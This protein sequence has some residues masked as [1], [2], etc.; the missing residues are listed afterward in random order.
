MIAN[1]VRDGVAVVTCPNR[2]TAQK[3][4]DEWFAIEWPERQW[5]VEVPR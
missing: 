1:I 2:E 4:V 5:T 3:R